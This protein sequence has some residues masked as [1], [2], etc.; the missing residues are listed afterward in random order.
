M[1]RYNEEIVPPA[2]FCDIRVAHTDI[3]HPVTLNALLDT[4]SDMSFIPV[5]VADELELQ[6]L[7]TGIVEGISGEGVSRPIFYALIS[8][9][10]SPWGELEVMGWH[11]DFALLGRDILNQYHITLDGPNLTLTIS[12]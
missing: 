5:K 10:H 8:V 1:Y 3:P 9:D 4:G 6:F 11:T 2:P 7:G 12:R